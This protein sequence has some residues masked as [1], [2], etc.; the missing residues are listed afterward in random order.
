MKYLLPLLLL[1]AVPAYARTWQ[2]NLIQSHG[3][4]EV[5]RQDAIAMMQFAR[6]K[7]AE[8]GIRT[9]IGRVSYT[10]LFNPTYNLSNYWQGVYWWQKHFPA[11][12]NILRHVVTPPFLVDQLWYIAGASPGVCLLHWRYAVST[13]NA[14]IVNVYNIDR[15]YQSAMA[16][17]HELGHVFGGRHTMSHSIMN[18]GALAFPDVKDLKFAPESVTQIYKCI[19]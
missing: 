8:V 6:A 4:R 11:R 14:Q 17:T 10:K 9:R 2:I 12:L 13:S 5:S 15:W 16:I 3:P 1:F 7:L 18:G 19:G